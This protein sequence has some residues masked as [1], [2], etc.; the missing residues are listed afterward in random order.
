[1]LKIVDPL[2]TGKNRKGSCSVGHHKNSQFV[3]ESG[4]KKIVICVL[5]QLKVVSTYL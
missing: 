2:T 3:V 5:K 4:T 1:M